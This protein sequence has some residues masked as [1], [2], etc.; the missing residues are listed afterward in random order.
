MSLPL[1]DL[2]M[3]VG[4]SMLCES[5]WD[6]LGEGNPSWVLLLVPCQCTKAGL[7]CG[8][9]LQEQPRQQLCCFGG[10]VWS[11]HICPVWA[12]LCPASSQSQSSAG[13]GA[14]LL[15][16][17]EKQRLVQSGTAL[18]ERARPM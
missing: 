11:S 15:C 2:H 1:F 7:C 17:V 3:R 9:A 6:L 8:M 14:E 10:I 16:P 18:L 4:T 13:S 5:R 12:L